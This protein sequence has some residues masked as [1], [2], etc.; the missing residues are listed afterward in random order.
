MF[1]DTA[2]ETYI[3]AEA[4]GG[5]I[6]RINRK[7]FENRNLKPLPGAGDPK[8]RYN[9]NTPIHMSPTQKGVVYL[10]AQFLFRTRDHGQ[11]WE[12]ISPD[13]TTNDPL[14][15]KQ[16]LSGGV[17]VDNSAAEMHTTIYAIAES[18]KD[19]NL[20]WVGTDDGN[21]QLTRDGGKTWTNVDA[22]HRRPAE[23]RLGVLRRGRPLRRGHRLRH[24]RP[25]T[26]SAT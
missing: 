13:L 9:W 10:G 17:T 12:R 22:Q 6:G 11:T 2:D 3:Y 8:L 23:E 18:P 16:E 5:E 15:Q 24:L 7:T 1:A 14:K 25:A 26:P 21:V 19:P 4:Q 20:I